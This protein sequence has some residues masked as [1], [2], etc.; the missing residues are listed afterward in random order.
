[1]SAITPQAQPT[2]PGVS[3]ATLYDVLA[4]GLQAHPELSVR[5]DRAASI[6]LAGGV[7][8]G[9]AAGWWVRSETRDTEYWVCQ[10]ANYRVDRCTCPDYRQRGG[11]CKHALSVRLLEACQQREAR[12][13]AA[14]ERHPRP[15]PACGPEPIALPA[16]AYTDADRFELT[17]KGE[18][19]LA[20]LAEPAPVA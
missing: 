5:L 7:Q 1:M 2:T 16:R 14:M 10:G 19:Y 20:A 15:A 6:V 3:P 4:R 17:P 18:A 11:P 9:Q 13:R 8:P 12:V